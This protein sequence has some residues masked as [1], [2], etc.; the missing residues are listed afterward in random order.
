MKDKDSK[1]FWMLQYPER[2]FVFFASCF[3]VLFLLLVPPFQSP[4]EYAHFYRAYQISEGRM[5]A[6]VEYDY[7]GGYLPE[8]LLTTAKGLSKGIPY[9]FA[10]GVSVDAHFNQHEKLTLS[11]FT[12]LLK[13]PV[14]SQQ[15]V[16]LA[17]PNTAS[18]SPI[19]YLPHQLGL[20]LGRLFNFSPILLFYVA[21]AFNLLV[22]ICLV[23]LAI[24]TIPILKRVFFL[25]ALTPMSLFIA[26]TLSADAFTNAISFLIISVF[27]RYTCDNNK[28]IKVNDMLILGALSILLSLSKQGYGLMLFL[29]FLIPVDKMKTIKAGKYKHI[30]YL[31][32]FI[33]LI[34]VNLAVAAFWSSVVRDIVMIP[35]SYAPNMSAHQQMN[36]I[37][38]HP[39]T[40]CSTIVN[41]FIRRHFYADQLIG[42]LGWLDTPM[43]TFIVY[44]YFMVLVVVSLIERD[45][46]CVI[47]KVKKILIFGTMLST[48]LAI[49]TIG[50]LFWMPVGANSI[51][52][53]Q[54]RYFIPV[55]PLLMLLLYNT[56]ISNQSVII[57]NIVFEKH[58]K[59]IEY[60]RNNETVV[61]LLVVSYSVFT[62]SCTLS[63]LFQRYWDHGGFRLD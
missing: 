41:T 48:I 4:D 21:R 2:V 43:P 59:I 5:V 20:M 17:F 14:N 32:V 7:I 49:S 54:G 16:F 6:E 61:N 39:L 57:K 22:W 44:S 53:I 26:S 10:M 9:P 24:K 11:D 56:A 50:Y 23:A 45:K 51:D 55:F 19:P 37:L 30:K 29:F 46:L 40:Y 42:V 31:S 27:V 8:S 28:E 18:Y 47:S 3:G 13:L 36:F 52:G 25:L 1:P 38:S 15:R 58:V 60:L 12:S 33:A 63:V 62:L 34:S 35:L